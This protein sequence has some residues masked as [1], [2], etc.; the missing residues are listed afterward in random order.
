MSS[1]LSSRALSLQCLRFVWHYVFSKCFG[2]VVCS[3]FQ[4]CLVVLGIG[5]SHVF[6]NFYAFILAGREKQTQ[7]SSLWQVRQTVQR[8]ER[9]YVT[10]VISC[11]SVRLHTIFGFGCNAMLMFGVLTNRT[12]Q[13]KLCFWRRFVS[14]GGIQCV[15]HTTWR[16]LVSATIF[17]KFLEPC[18]FRWIVAHPRR[19]ANLVVAHCF[20]CNFVFSCARTR[21]EDGQVCEYVRV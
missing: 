10:C 2:F 15:R 19:C 8:K 1:G 4:S 16:F 3:Q 20:R 7:Y 11:S 6:F 5:S 12:V 21:A 14:H 17:G 13:S 9:Y 18:F